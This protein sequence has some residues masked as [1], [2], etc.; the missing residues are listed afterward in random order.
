MK[1]KNLEVMATFS[2]PLRVEMMRLLSTRK[3]TVN[4]LADELPLTSGGVRP[5][6][7]YFINRK[8]L[9]TKRHGRTVHYWLN[10]ERLVEALSEF[11]VE[12]GIDVSLVTRWSIEESRESEGRAK[13]PRKKKARA[14]KARAKKTKAKKARAKKT[15][16]KKA[17]TKKKVSKRRASATTK[18]SAK[19]TKRGRKKAA[20]KRG[21]RGKKTT[22]RR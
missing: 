2:H 3:M 15:K 6:L 14:K 12:A 8:L 10:R 17:R 21:A 13:K 4:E 20:K 5:H 7:S 16:A 9:H 22:S 11:G 19:A 1:R 18:R